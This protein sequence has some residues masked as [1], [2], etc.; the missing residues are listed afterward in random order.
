MP[1]NR[2]IKFIHNLVLIQKPM[3][4]VGAGIAFIVLQS[5]FISF[6]SKSKYVENLFTIG[7]RHCQ[8]PQVNILL[9]F[10]QQLLRIYT[11]SI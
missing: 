8:C 10:W 2:I 7:H 6:S 9:L 11:V 5:V 3:N 1:Y 4:S